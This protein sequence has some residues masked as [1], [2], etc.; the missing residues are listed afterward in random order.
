QS[1]AAGADIDE[2]QVVVAIAG[3][4]MKSLLAADTSETTTRYRL[5]DTTRAYALGKLLSSG[6]ADQTARRHAMNYLKLLERA[7]ANPVAVPYDKSSAGFGVLANVRAALE[8]SFLEQGD[9]GLGVTLAAAS[10]P[11]FL[12]SSLL[13]ECTRWMERSLAKLDDK[14]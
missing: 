8:W 2:S 4:V 5:L 7:S 6:D 14:A 12:E 1:V 3:L 9:A 13:A 11:L 10:V